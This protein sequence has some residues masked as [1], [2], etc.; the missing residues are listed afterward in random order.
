MGKHGKPNPEEETQPLVTV[1]PLT[2]PMPISNERLR[3]DVAI[4]DASIKRYPIPEPT[5][6]N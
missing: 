1:V 3:K 2:N 4:I 5:V 6:R